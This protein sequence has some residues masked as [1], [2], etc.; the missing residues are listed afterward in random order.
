[1]GH[2]TERRWHRGHHRC[3]R[4]RRRARSRAFPCS[5]ETRPAVTSA[6]QVPVTPP[7]V[8]ARTLANRRRPLRRAPARRARRLTTWILVTNEYSAL[9]QHPDL[10]W[11]R[12]SRR[13]THRSVHSRQRQRPWTGR[14]RRRSSVPGSSWAVRP[15]E[16]WPKFSPS[17]AVMR[18]DGRRATRSPP[19]PALPF[20][21]ARPARPR[22]AS[23][24]PGRPGF[25]VGPALPALEAACF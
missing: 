1:M 24:P 10:P 2:T 4:R 25:Q 11:G 19:A 8:H 17:S 18:L 6:Q 22:E 9:S 14:W 21:A 5:G 20:G 16:R 7:L 15:T 23:A 3:R 13:R 12:R